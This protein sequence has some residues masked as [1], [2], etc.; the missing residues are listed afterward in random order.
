MT[1][2]GRISRRTVLRGV[3]TVVALPFLDAMLPRLRA[4]ETAPEKAGA[5]KRMA[6]IY[7]PN[8]VHMQEWTPE[9]EGTDFELPSIL[10]PLAA[11]RDDVLVLSGLTCDKGRP[12]GD[13]AGDHARA[14]SAFLTGAQARKTSGANFRSGVSADQI[15]AQKLG[16]QTRLASLELGIEAFRGTG[17]CDSGY[18]CV[19]EH[20]LAWRNPTTPLPTEVNPKLIFERLF[21]DQPNDPD[22]LKRGRLRASVLDAVLD[23]AHSLERQLGGADRQ[24]LD[25]YLSSVRDLEDRIHRAEKLP[26]VEPPEGTKKP[27]QL[28]ADLTEHFHLVSDLFVLA[29]QT[30]VTRVVTFMFGREGSD[31]KY[32]MVGVKEGHHSIT[33]HQGKKE[34]QDKIKAINTYHIEQYAYLIGKLKAVKEGEGTLLDNCM[35]AYGSAIADGNAHEHGDLPV[36][37]AGRGGGTI[38][39]GR[40]IRYASE[41]PLNN[42]WLAMLER[43]GA[44]TPRLGDSTG[45]L[46]KLA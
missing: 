36:L 4:A 34:L 6:F 18:S 28:P 31:Q 37:L 38:R 2:S 14:S 8:G 21:A 41:T 3:G 11:V 17:N 22:R 16:D 5:P 13:G 9:K 26:P 39:S 12:N 29:L 25:Q 43:F 44:K 40:H 35:V 19:Y 15:A 30:D 46:D 33:H 27:E 10:Q 23:D 1:T 7:V 24:K 32:P 42:L 20:T 45:I